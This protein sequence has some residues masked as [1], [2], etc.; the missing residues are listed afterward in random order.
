MKTN[1]YKWIAVG[2]AIISL[3]TISYLIGQNSKNQNLSTSNPT[4]NIGTNQ[5]I[6]SSPN[7]PPNSS[8]NSTQNNSSQITSTDI[9]PYLTG[10]VEVVCSKM[11]TSGVEQPNDTGSA[12]LW[13]FSGGNYDV[14]TNEHVIA[15]NDQCYIYN[16][17]VGAY[18]LDLSNIRIWNGL[19][20]EAIIPISLPS[21]Q[22]IPDQTGL[23]PISKLNYGISS[24]R[25]CPSDMPQNSPVVVIGF[26]AFSSMLTHNLENIYKN[27]ITTN[28]TVSGYDSS[29]A[30]GGLPD[31]NYYI[32]AT[33][34]SG[35]SGGISFS[36]D[37]NGLCL[38][39]I[40]T[41]I[42]STGNYSDEGIVQNIYNIL[43]KN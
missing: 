20:D 3:I 14:V 40:P 28:G 2:I 13:S 5:K 26:P 18:N 39:G 16:T 33:I 23:P 24:L 35:N 30:N 12:S 22:L 25:D 34:D 6:V 21:L 7:P 41:W 42:T 32:S 36:K 27:E 29:P 19:A 8:P 37:S 15:G 10:V 17:D 1:S 4:S 38:L 31:S 43:Y 9:A 11:N